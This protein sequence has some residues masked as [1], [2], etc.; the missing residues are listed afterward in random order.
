[1]QGCAIGP[2]TIAAAIASRIDPSAIEAFVVTAKS[3]PKTVKTGR[4]LV[5][6][7]EVCQI[8]P[9]AVTSEIRTSDREVIQN[10]S[11]LDAYAKDG[12]IGCFLDAQ[13]LTESVKASRN[14][15][16]DKAN[17]EYLRFLSAS[18]ISGELSF[19]SPDR[20]RAPPGMIATSGKCA[21]IPQM[22]D[23]RRSHDL[24]IEL[25]KSAEKTVP[26]MK[27]NVAVFVPGG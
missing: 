7:S 16:T 4:W 10:L 27:N 18:L 3:D 11:A 17:T 15:S 22:P 23:I 12:D 19:Y 20:L 1:M 21:E 24:L 6:S 5:L 13:G 8:R 2:S 26:V 9:P 14:W 25:R